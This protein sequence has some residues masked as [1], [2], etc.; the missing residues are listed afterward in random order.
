MQAHVAKCAITPSTMQYYPK[1]TMAAA[2]KY[3]SNMEIAKFQ[4]TTFA[5]LLNS[6]TE[7]LRR[8]LPEDGRYVGGAAWGMARKCL[9]IFLRDAL[10][11]SYLRN[12]YNLV[13]LERHMEVPLDSHTMDAIM[14]DIEGIF[15]ST[16]PS[17][18]NL[19]P[20]LSDQ[21]QDVAAKIAAR[22][23]TYK[24]HLDL[25]FWRSNT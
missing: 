12:E 15:L 5:R 16:R 20:D 4:V 17:I 1:E 3:L 7:M 18:A 10:Y 11:N 19:T 8:T 25:L 14:R 9:N 23:S 24:V 22:M 13:N 2:I 6:Q 21:Y